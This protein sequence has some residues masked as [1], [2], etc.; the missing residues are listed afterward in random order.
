[1]QLRECVLNAIAF[2]ENADQFICWNDFMNCSSKAKTKEVKRTKSLSSN[3]TSALLWTSLFINIFASYLRCVICI[4]VSSCC[5]VICRVL[6]QTYFIYDINNWQN[7]KIN[8]KIL[9]VFNSHRLNF[10][11]QMVFCVSKAPLQ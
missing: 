11:I 9:K 3:I 2:T 7:T 5:P 1:M 10:I 8:Y 6:W 4:L